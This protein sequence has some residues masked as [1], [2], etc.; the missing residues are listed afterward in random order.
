MSKKNIGK[1]TVNFGTITLFSIQYAEIYHLFYNFALSLIPVTMTTEQ[2]NSIYRTVC[3]VPRGNGF[4]VERMPDFFAT[5]EIDDCMAHVHSFYEILWFQ[6]GEGIH[7]VDFKDYEVKPGTI[8]FLAPGQVHHFDKEEGYKGVAIKMCTDMMKDPASGNNDS[9]LF[10][11]YNSFHTYDSTPYYIIDAQ[12]A[13]ML[14]PLVSQMEEEALRYG[15]FGNMDI[16]KSLLCI[17]LVK[18]QRHGYHEA[19]KDLD[20]LKPAHQLFVQFRRMVEEEH[21]R[22]H[23]VQEYADRLNV[24]VRTLN[25]SVNECSGKS[26]LAF[27]NDRIVLE[28]KRMVKYTNLMIK[29][30]A[31]DLGYDDASYFVKMFKRQTGYL[32]SEFRDM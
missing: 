16:L 7:T 8:F 25:K 20:T 6:E 15:E 29:E 30:I 32:P 14:S 31:S 3:N 2:L 22:L 24:A 26:P 10:M 1:E 21:H 12:T 17:F 5:S 23:T 4:R 13:E 19:G 9:S 11:K 28:A 27:I 18:I